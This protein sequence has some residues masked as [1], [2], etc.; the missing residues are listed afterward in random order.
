MN[1]MESVQQI[2]EAQRATILAIGTENPPN[3]ILQDDQPDFF[4]RVTKSDH[5]RDLK[6]KFERLC[7]CF[8]GLRHSFMSLSNCVHA[9]VHNVENHF[10]VF[11]RGKF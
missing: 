4:F 8:L 11:I 1:Q 7:E 10:S 5:M 6:Q 2:R 9:N 3:V